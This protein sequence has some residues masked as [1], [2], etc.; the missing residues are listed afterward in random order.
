MSFPEEVCRHREDYFNDE[1]AFRLLYESPK[2]KL[3]G[4]ARDGGGHGGG[5]G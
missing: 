1:P 5:R 2:S 3:I 4:A